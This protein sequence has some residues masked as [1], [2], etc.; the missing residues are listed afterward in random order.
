MLFKYQ[1]I[2]SVILMQCFE[3][4]STDY[5]L[6]QKEKNIFSGVIYCKFLDSA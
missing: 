1:L 2:V 4:I 3:V 5:S 6:H